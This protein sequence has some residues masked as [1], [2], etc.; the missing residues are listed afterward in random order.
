[1]T[2]TEHNER[3]EIIRDVLL[4]RDRQIAKWGEQFH[5]DDRWLVIL[6]EEFGEVARGIFE[7]DE[8]NVDEELIQ[9]MAVCMAWLEDRRTRARSR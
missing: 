9:C 5:N 8:A 1:M 4:E 6:A 3:V 7:G 2:G